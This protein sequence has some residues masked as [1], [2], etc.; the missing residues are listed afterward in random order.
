M[1]MSEYYYMNGLY[2]YFFATLRMSMGDFSMIAAVPYL[3]A[4]D[5][6][7]FWFPWLFCVVLLFIVFLNY[8]VAEACNSYSSISGEIESH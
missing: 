8:V 7:F 2:T 4:G 3:G 5:S 1:P 6:I